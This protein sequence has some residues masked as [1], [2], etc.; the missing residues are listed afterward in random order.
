MNTTTRPATSILS[1]EGADLYY[2]LRGQGPLIALHAAPMDAASF[3]P[4]AELLAADHTV[5]TSDPRGISRSTVRDGNRDVTPEMRADDLAALL[6][7]IDVGRA[8]VFGSSGGAVSGL[9]L[10]QAHPELADTVIAHEPPLAGL[11][12]DSAELRRQ[13]DD[14]IETYL[15]GDRRRAW[16]KFMATANIRLPDETFEAMFGGPIE[17]QAAADERFSFARMERATTFWMPDLAALRATETRLII[18][19]GEESTDELCDRTSRALAADLG[20][21]PTTFPG[22]HVGFAEGPEAFA[23]RLRQVLV[24]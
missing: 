9:A 17:G 20:I 5:L 21:Q 2:E 7:H 16:E 11:L 4:L 15:A 24:A 12:D 22:G 18:A 10:I 14:M 8:T 1:V 13:T 3:T 6:R 23:A 19:I